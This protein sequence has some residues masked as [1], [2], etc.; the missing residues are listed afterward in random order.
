MSKFIKFLFAGGTAAAV[1]IL[2][3]YVFDIF[4]SYDLAIILAYLCGML[5]AF[6]LNKYFVFNEE[7][8]NTGKEAI[9]F[10]IVNLFALLVVWAVSVFFAR[11]IFPAINWTYYP[12]DVAHI[13]GVISTVF[14]SYLGHK[15]YTFRN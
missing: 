13:I 9:R 15:Y 10:I 4:M 5:T 14:T 11:L 3:R 7:S 8:R 6:L 2:S 12:D 1:N